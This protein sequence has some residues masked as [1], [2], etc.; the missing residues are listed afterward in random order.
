MINQL[1]KSQ[2]LKKKEKSLNQ[3]KK[4]PLKESSKET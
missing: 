2:S 4:S 3:R 1:L